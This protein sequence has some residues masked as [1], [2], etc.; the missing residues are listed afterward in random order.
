[1]R[2]GSSVDIYFHSVD[3]GVEKLMMIC[4]LESGLIYPP[5]SGLKDL[6]VYCFIGVCTVRAMRV[7]FDNYLMVLTVLRPESTSLR[8]IYLLYYLWYCL[9]RVPYKRQASGAPLM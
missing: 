5:F 9:G 3:L 8:M 1:M 6:E 7:F 2:T 4:A